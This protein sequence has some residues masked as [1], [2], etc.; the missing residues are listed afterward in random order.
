MTNTSLSIG[1]GMVTGNT[2]LMVAPE[3]PLIVHA[4]LSVLPVLVSLL[5]SWL[6]GISKKDK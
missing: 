5:T 6:K 1:A 4:I 2:S 3:Q